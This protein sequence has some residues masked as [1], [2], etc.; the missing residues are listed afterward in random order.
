MQSLLN[1]L[2]FKFDGGDNGADK[3]T[4][5]QIA[6]VWGGIGLLVGRFVSQ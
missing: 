4:G 5:A 6:I 1:A 2:T 3:P